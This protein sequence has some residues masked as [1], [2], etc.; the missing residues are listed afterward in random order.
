M[1]NWPKSTVTF[2]KY[3]K[4]RVSNKPEIGVLENQT[5]SLS[6]ESTVSFHLLGIS[7]YLHLQGLLLK[8][9]WYSKDGL[10]KRIGSFWESGIGS[11]KNW[12]PLFQS[13]GTS[14]C[15][16]TWPLWLN[17]SFKCRLSLPIKAA[18]VYGHISPHLTSP[19]LGAG[20]EGYCR[21]I[22]FGFFRII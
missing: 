17:A 6:F 14:Q 11:N 4:F 21:G 13:P 18:T 5:G 20:A 2:M 3:L 22:P 1:C 19:A 10:K 16:T 12:S 15:C 8:R 9:T 7:Q